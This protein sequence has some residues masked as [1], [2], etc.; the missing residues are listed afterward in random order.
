MAD[1]PLFTLPP[2][3]YDKPPYG[4]NI[5]LK[6]IEDEFSIQIKKYEYLIEAFAND[7]FIINDEWI[8]RFPRT[9]Q[10]KEHYKY[11]V[12]FL[13]YLKDKVRVNI[14]EYTYIS[15]DVSFV[16]YKLIPGKYM[17]RDVFKTLGKADREQVISKLVEFI[18]AFHRL[19]MAD[20][21]TYE[22]INKERYIS[23]EQRI[24][25]DLESELYPK[26][27]TL[28]VDMIKGFYKKSKD[29]LKNIP[30][31]CPIHGDLYAYNVLWDKNNKKV[32]IIDFSDY[33]VG[34][35]A[36][37][38]EIFYDFGAEYAQ[39]AYEKYQGSKD[40]NFLRRSEIYYKAHGIYTL[41]SSISGAKISFD[42]AY[43]H[44]FKEKFE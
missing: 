21:K 19:D 40:D 4:V 14:P 2:P 18:N 30:G 20:F 9:Q 24:E 42:I 6:K 22:P 10:T 35:P 12:E 1:E 23:I 25:N 16:G 11:E 32:G 15:K 39:L 29:V 43:K 7:V 8:F 34:D 37:D 31:D 41:L 36:R 13:R 3:F 33:M 28:D 17:T 26:L 38:F 5:Y 27:S 44:F